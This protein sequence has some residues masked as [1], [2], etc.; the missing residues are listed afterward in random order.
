MFQEGEKVVAYA[1]K[2]TNAHEQNYA[3]TEL[4]A[5]AAVWAIDKFRLY[6]NDNPFTLVTDHKALM[7][8]RE[9]SGKSAKLERWSLKLQDLK[10]D[11]KHKEGSKMPADYIS[12][13]RITL[14]INR[15]Q[16]KENGIKIYP[17]VD[18]SEFIKTLNKDKDFKLLLEK[19]KK[20]QQVI[21]KEREEVY[22]DM[23]RRVFWPGMFKDVKTY[24]EGCKTFQSRN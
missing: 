13:N 14:I 10:F 2:S 18:V 23:I 20:L 3:A 22:V 4:E 6:L 11:I 17:I 5:G 19:I 16:T 21:G 24:C 7:K 1:S 8:F 12:R 15:K 9:I